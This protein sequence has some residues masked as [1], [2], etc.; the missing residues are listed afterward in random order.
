MAR[1]I[2]A[3]A[4]ALLLLVSVALRTACDS[5]SRRRPVVQTEVRTV[6]PD[7]PAE[8]RYHGVNFTAYR[9]TRAEPTRLGRAQ[10]VCGKTRQTSGAGPVTVWRFPGQSPSKVILRARYDV[11]YLVYVA[12]SVLPGER[13]RVLAEVRS[14]KR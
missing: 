13:R 14:D 8:L 11:R 5:S 10:P 6:G 12:D 3:T 2:H 4:A 7:C 1:Q 9:L